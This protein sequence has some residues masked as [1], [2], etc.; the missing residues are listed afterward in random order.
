MGA[1]TDALFLGDI[2][3]FQVDGGGRSATKD[4][5]R[6]SSSAIGGVLSFS[7]RSGIL[8]SDPAAVGG[9]LGAPTRGVIFAAVTVAM[10]V[11]DPNNGESP[12]AGVGIVEAMTAC[13]PG[14][15]V[16]KADLRLED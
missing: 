3:I 10:L 12:G 16:G 6:S 9:L 2:F 4:S 7:G 11:I 1:P 14:A 5:G 15:L 13:E 8:L